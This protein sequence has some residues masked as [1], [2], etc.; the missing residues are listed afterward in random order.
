MKI[1]FSGSISGGRE[2]S[3]IYEMIIK[4]L[5]NY[6]KVLTEHIG[7]KSLSNLGENKSSEYLYNRDISFINESDVVI[8]DIT[9]PSL[10]VGYEIAYA[11]KLNKKIFCIYHPIEGKR[12]SAMITGNPNLKVFPYTSHKEILEILKEIFK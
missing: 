4:E 2:H 9:T 1:Y 3:H 6:G 5:N 7:D 10:G 8:A 11:E 12:I